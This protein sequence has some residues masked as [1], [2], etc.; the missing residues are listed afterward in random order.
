MGLLLRQANIIRNSLVMLKGGLY[1]LRHLQTPFLI[2]GS[3]KDFGAGSS[4]TERTGGSDAGDI[5]SSYINF[6]EV[7]PF[8]V[9]GAVGKGIFSRK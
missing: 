5:V 4:V 2:V 1:G 6:D 9:V 8:Q 3:M 7:A